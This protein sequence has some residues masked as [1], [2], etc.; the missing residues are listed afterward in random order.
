MAGKSFNEFQRE[1]NKRGIEG[2]MAIV[3]TEMYEQIR[4]LAEQSD[5]CAK[6]LMSLANTVGNVVELH[7]VTQGQVAGL[8]ERMAG[9]ASGVELSSVPLRDEPEDN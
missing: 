9:D 7:H 4:D 2:H 3:L 8:R 1:L 6:V 5:Q